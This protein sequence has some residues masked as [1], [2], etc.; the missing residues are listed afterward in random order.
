MA[1]LIPQFTHQDYEIVEKQ[2]P[3]KGY[4]TL[5]KYWIRH[6]LFSG[7]WSPVFQREMFERSSAVAIL[8]YDP[9]LD[10]VI[11]IQQFRAGALTHPENPWLLEIVAG[12][13]EEN[14][15]PEAVAIREA[16]EEAGCIIHSLHPICDY[17]VS[18]GGSN[19]HVYVYVGR[20]DASKIHGIHGLIE[21]NEDINTLNLTREEALGLLHQGK[22]KTSPAILSLQWLEYNRN[23]LLNI[24]QQK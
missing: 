24:W 18:P 21:E 7:G 16:E 3:Y 10:R 12:I 19:E 14:E 6:K 9:T 8:P 5:A 23:H 13:Y 17:Y 20:T 22:I 2:V 1:V 4:F 15:N 11:L